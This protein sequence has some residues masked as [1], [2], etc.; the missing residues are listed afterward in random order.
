ML[1]AYAVPI[2]VVIGLYTAGAIG[3]LFAPR[4]FLGMLFGVKTDD[5]FTLFIAR[6]WALLASLVGALLVYAAFHPEVRAPA[7]LVAIV[8]KLSVAPLLFLGP[9]RRTPAATRMAVIDGAMGVIL[10]GCLVG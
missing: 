2:L 5:A 8:E 9:W 7:L 6:H 1:S 10:A 3:Q 4:A